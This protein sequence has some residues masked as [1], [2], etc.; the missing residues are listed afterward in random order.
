MNL[1]SNGKNAPTA[2][3][4]VVASIGVESS[5]WLDFGGQRR[6][7]H[8][9]IKALPRSNNACFCAFRAFS[10]QIISSAFP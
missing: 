3:N 1:S 9:E 7:Y 6:H 4:P 5:L 8:N 10:R 2:S